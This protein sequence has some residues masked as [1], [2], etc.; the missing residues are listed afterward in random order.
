MF[1][2]LKSQIKSNFKKIHW[3]GALFLCI[4]PPLG[5]VLTIY[6]LKTEGFLWPIWLLAVVFY[7]IT[8]SSIT[9]GYHR[10]FSHRA[11]KSKTWLKWFWAIWGAAAFQNS[12]YIWAR[13]HRL[14]HRYV[15][16]D[17]DPYTIKKGFFYAHF[18]WMLI[19]SPPD[20][21]LD[22]YGRDLAQCPVVQFQHK[23]YEWIAV[24]AG[25]V[26]PTVIGYF[27]GSALGGFAVAG[28]LRMTMLHHMTFFI[29]SACHYFGSQKYT[30][31]N[32]ARDCLWAAVATFGEGYHNFHHF[33]AS[34]YRNG[35]RW[36]HW[37]P[38]KWMIQFFHLLGGAYQLRRTPWQEILRAQLQMDEK[39]LKTQLRSRWHDQWQ[40]HLD[41]LKFKV[42]A[43][44]ARFEELKREYRAGDQ[45]RQA[46][47]EFRAAIRQW[48]AYNSYLLSAATA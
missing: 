13:E 21:D 14:H 34:D 39:R 22:V 6:H 12:I 27:L 25:F 11:Y 48:R 37:D 35:V 46:R 9:G 4:T 45:I 40:A 44:H 32:T 38:T 43:A 7:S 15:D 17:R 36:Y 23:Y 2:Q 28:L 5:L 47:A 29:N 26:T 33:F 31:V 1:T 30:D 42:E 19:E 24:L 18:G 41:A 16:T 3:S 10:Y 8:A 20:P